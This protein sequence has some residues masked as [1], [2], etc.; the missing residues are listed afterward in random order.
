MSEKI[1]VIG[2]GFLGSSIVKSLTGS[3]TKIFSS[4]FNNL[5]E[6]QFKID[7]RDLDS[8]EKCVASLKPDFIINF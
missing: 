5:K 7:V 1:L 6:N 4:G 2:G 3:K 8:I